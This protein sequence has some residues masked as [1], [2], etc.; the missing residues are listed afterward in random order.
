MEIA[1]QAREESF[2]NDSCFMVALFYCSGV[3]KQS[4]QHKTNV[5]VYCRQSHKCVWNTGLLLFIPAVFCIANVLQL[6]FISTCTF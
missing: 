5:S 6:C 3:E 4:F 2:L 1:K